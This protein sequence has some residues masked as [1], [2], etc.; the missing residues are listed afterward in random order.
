MAP[1]TPGTAPIPQ[2]NSDAAEHV[3]E[4][5]RILSGLRQQLDR[6]PDLEEAI[7][8]LELALSVLTTR[9]GGML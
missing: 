1:D 5:H 9:T 2:P 4:A 7:A 3:A 6:H 8:R